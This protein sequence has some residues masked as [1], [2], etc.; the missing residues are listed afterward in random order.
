MTNTSK[1]S[2]NEE[3]STSEL[4][5]LLEEVESLQQESS[6]Q[7]GDLL[8]A[9]VLEKLGQNS[10]ASAQ[11]REE[12]TEEEELEL[13]QLRLYQARHRSQALT[14]RIPDWL[15]L[16]KTKPEGSESNSGSSPNT[17]Q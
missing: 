17:P 8:L 11:E 10:T 6:D 5:Q 1:P 15:P 7:F 14:G 13:G 9:E 3:P 4:E 12:V 2:E 16:P